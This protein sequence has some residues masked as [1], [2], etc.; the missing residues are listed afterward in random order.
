MHQSNTNILLETGT[1]EL[2]I[3]EFE[4]M[5]KNKDVMQSFGINVAKVREI[6]K[7]PEF[8][9]I[10]SAHPNVI[11]VFKLRNKII[12]LISLAG[13]LN[14]DV[15]QIDIRRCYV[16]VTEFNK[17]NFGFLVHGI[18]RIHRMSWEKVLAPT[19]VDSFADIGSITG[20]VPFNDRIMLM[21]D[22]EKIVTNINTN[23]GLDLNSVTDDVTKDLD[24]AKGSRVIVAEDSSLIRDLMHSILTKAGFEVMLFQNGR[25]AWEYM[26]MIK[27]KVSSEGSNLSDYIKALVSDIEM[28]QMDGHSLCKN[29]K[30][31]SLLKSLPVVLFS[32]LIYEEMRKKGDAVGANAQI[33]K[34][35]IGSL[36]KIVNDLI[37]NSQSN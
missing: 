27:E 35:E 6:I 4:I 10:P 19:N 28:P 34:P 11:G 8:I 21:I 14:E 15:D 37:K 20:I 7:I 18:K 17:D 32:S 9:K 3:A 2:E 23:V 25:L 1:N 13:W 22:F 30:E 36:V 16:I 29:V 33:S 5:L 12:P 31:D 26:N 24:V